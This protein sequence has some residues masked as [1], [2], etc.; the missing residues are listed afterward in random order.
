[1]MVRER[2]PE[3]HA[4]SLNNMNGILQSKVLELKVKVSRNPK[5]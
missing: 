1:M 2:G 5:P 4:N 3:K